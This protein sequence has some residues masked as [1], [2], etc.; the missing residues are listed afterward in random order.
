MR[1]S[2][3]ITLAVLLLPGAAVLARTDPPQH[4]PFDYLPQLGDDPTLSISSAAL[5]IRK[6]TTAN[7]RYLLFSGGVQVS[8][9]GIELS[10][11]EVELDIMATDLA[12]SDFKLP[13]LPDEVEHLVDDPGGVIAEMAG[14]LDLPSPKLTS[15]LQRVGARGSVVVKLEN[16]TLTTDTL[17]STD[18]GRSWSTSG[19]SRLSGSDPESGTALTLAMEHLLVDTET[20]RAIARGTVR[21]QIQQPQEEEIQIS[22]ESLEIDLNQKLINVSDSLQIKRGSLLM[23]CGTFSANIE[24]NSVDAGGGPRLTDSERDI[25]AELGGIRY[26]LDTQELVAFGGVEITDE[27]RD[28]SLRAGELRGNIVDQ[29]FVARGEPRVRYGSSTFEGKVI[30]LRLLGDEKA[31]VEV[32]GPQAAKIFVDELGDEDSS[33]QDPEVK[34]GRP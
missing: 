26:D 1:L 18:G 28:L 20:N 23:T 4:D 12:D 32:D 31:L 33:A 16:F 3:W 15:A 25:H 2:L 24:G 17:V 29:L 14:D 9:E 30:T 22:A 13:A 27:S 19:N 8:T 7:T 11:D 5:S 21:C 10:A 34:T 6:T